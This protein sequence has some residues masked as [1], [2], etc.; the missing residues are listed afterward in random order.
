MA[1]ESESSDSNFNSLRTIETPTVE[2]GMY[3][4]TNSNANAKQASTSLSTMR[5]AQDK[6]NVVVTKSAGKINVIR[7]NE[8][9]NLEAM[10]ADNLLSCEAVP[11]EEQSGGKDEFL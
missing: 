2:P 8:V 6:A 3:S 7:P 4:K 11:A 10:L 5:S 9:E 1:T